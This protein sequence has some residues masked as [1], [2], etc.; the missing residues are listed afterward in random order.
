MAYELGKA[1]A[2][3]QDSFTTLLPDLIDG[4]SQQLWH[5]WTRS[6]ARRQKPSRRLE[7]V[8]GSTVYAFGEA[9]SSDVT[10]LL[11]WLHETQPELVDEFLDDAVENETLAE[12]YPL[13]E[14]AVR[15]ETA[16]SQCHTCRMD[17]RAE[18]MRSL[19]AYLMR[20]TPCRAFQKGIPVRERLFSTASSRNSSTSS[21]CV[22]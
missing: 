10:K 1:V 4:T 16:R 5:F 21:G 12:W 7:S 18:R 6:G 17:A 13:L 3:D 19:M 8:G 11:E 22:S 9:K 14:T 15:I 2:V 20:F